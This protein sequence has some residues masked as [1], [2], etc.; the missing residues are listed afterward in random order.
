MAIIADHYP[1]LLPSHSSP[2]QLATRVTLPFMGGSESGLVRLG[3]GEGLGTSLDEAMA[4]RHLGVC[5]SILADH[6]AN[7]PIS[8][9]RRLSAR[10]T[11]SEANTLGS[12]RVFRSLK[13]RR[14][15]WNDME[16]YGT[17]WNDMERY[18][19]IWNDMERYGTIWNDLRSV[20]KLRVKVSQ[21][22]LPRLDVVLPWL[23]LTKFLNPPRS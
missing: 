16:R 2:N 15:I 12:K 21:D 13:R 18:G 8:N 9:R 23:R 7:R 1:H 22:G 3:S 14:T 20:S 4:R 6:Y 5:M 11:R 19:T 17:I 10:L